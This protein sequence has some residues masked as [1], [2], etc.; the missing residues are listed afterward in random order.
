MNFRDPSD[1]FG[2]VFGC[3]AST[4]HI[5]RYNGCIYGTPRFYI[6][7]SHAVNGASNITR[8]WT[9]IGW[10]ICCLCTMNNGNN[11][12]GA[13]TA[14]HKRLYLRKTGSVHALCASA[15]TMIEF[16]GWRALSLRV[17]DWS[18]IINLY[19]RFTAATTTKISTLMLYPEEQEATRRAWGEV[20]KEKKNNYTT[21][22]WWITFG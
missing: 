17:H 5:A 19:Q 12:Q 7:I 2:F 21:I 14:V 16:F 11:M 4:I 20:V 10:P 8:H 6:F 3:C 9:H 22:K 1:C 15:G 13:A 18:F